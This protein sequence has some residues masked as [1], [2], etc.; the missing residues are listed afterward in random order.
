MR[1]IPLLLLLLFTSCIFEQKENTFTLENYFSHSIILNF[2]A[3]SYEV[4]AQEQLEIHDIPIG[5]YDFDIIYERPS[6]RT[7]DGGVVFLKREGNEN[8]NG[9]LN[10]TQDDTH[11]RLIITGV[12]NY[13]DTTY[14]IGYSLTFNQTN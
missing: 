14:T 12:L 5:S 10:L 6:I 8:L 3:S 4:K 2:R 7:S 1:F 11:Y 13:Q 9:I